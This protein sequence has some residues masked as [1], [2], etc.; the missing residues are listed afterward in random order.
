MTNLEHP[1][2]QDDMP[3]YTIIENTGIPG[4][5]FVRWP[6]GEFTVIGNAADD[7]VERYRAAPDEETRQLVLAEAVSEVAA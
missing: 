6:G 4:S 1:L 3:T 5:I 2:W 7:L